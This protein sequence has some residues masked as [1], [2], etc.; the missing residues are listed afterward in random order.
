MFIGHFSV[1]IVMI[2]LD[3]TN[4]VLSMILRSPSN[5]LIKYQIY[6]QHS[7]HKFVIYNIRVNLPITI[8]IDKILINI[9]EI[10]FFFFSKF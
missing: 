6:M 9:I 7:Y 2:E 1:G 8:R 4:L 10:P 3:E 5:H